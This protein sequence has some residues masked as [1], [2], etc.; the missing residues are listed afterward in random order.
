M[1]HHFEYF[2]DVLHC[3]VVVCKKKKLCSSLK[4]FDC[5]S[6]IFQWYITSCRFDIHEARLGTFETNMAA[7]KGRCSFATILRK[8]R[9][10]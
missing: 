3:R 8:N 10:L 5:F 6:Y 7:R 4:T 1:K 9:G 2:F